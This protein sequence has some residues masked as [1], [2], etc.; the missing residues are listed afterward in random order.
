LALSSKTR[1]LLVIGDPIEHSLSP[2]LQ[3]AALRAKGIDAVYLAARVTSG[4]LRDAVKGL[5]YLNCTGINVTMPHKVPIVELMDELGDSARAVEAVNTVKIVEEKLIG[6]NTDCVGVSEA[7]LRAGF[8][9]KGFKGVILGAG[10][11]ARAACIALSKLSPEL[12]IVNRTYATSLELAGKLKGEGIRAEAL[13]W[14]ALP[15]ALR[16]SNLVINATSRGMYPATEDSPVPREHLRPEMT[17]LDLIYYPWRTRLL[18]DAE[19]AGSRAVTG[20]DVLVYQGAES[21]RIWF[22]EEPDV[23]SMMSSAVEAARVRE[24]V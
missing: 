15:M 17:I 21:F 18:R 1:L 12:T 14:G 23:E 2:V 24:P 13:E 5:R 20:L 6:Y 8:D 10:G 9:M 3:N 16:G 19:S 7:L 22:G 11:A 4:G